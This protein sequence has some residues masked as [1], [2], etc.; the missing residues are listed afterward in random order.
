MYLFYFILFFLI[1]RNMFS[2]GEEKNL[3]EYLKIYHL[4][5]KE[6]K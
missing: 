6:I 5:E 4:S 2:E 3:I 1:F